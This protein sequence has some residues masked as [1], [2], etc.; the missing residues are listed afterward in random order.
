MVVIYASVSS[1]ASDPVMKHFMMNSISFWRA[2][3]AWAFFI[4]FLLL[5]PRRPGV[6]NFLIFSLFR[7]IFSFLAFTRHPK[8]HVG[9]ERRAGSEKEGRTVKAYRIE[10][11]KKKKNALDNLRILVGIFI[12]DTKRNHI[13]CHWSQPK[14]KALQVK[15]FETSCGKSYCLCC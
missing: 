12:A 11:M 9:D 6:E 4:I 14:P 2:S 15:A 10:N 3:D 13:P 7:L 1:S 8:R 5:V